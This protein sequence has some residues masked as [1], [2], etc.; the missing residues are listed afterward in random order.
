MWF[1]INVLERDLGIETDGYM[2]QM[3]KFTIQCIAN[4]YE[5]DLGLDND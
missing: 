2:T 4:K 5:I 3:L 1:N